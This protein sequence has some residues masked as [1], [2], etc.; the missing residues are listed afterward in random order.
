MN[1]SKAKDKCAKAK[2]K[3]KAKVAAKCGGKTKKAVAALAAL[4]LLAIGCQQVPSRS[5]TLTIRD[6][7]VNVYGGSDTNHVAS[8]EIGTQAMSIE[9]SGTE[10]QSPTQTT[11][12]KPDVDV[13]VGAAK[14]GGIL[15]TAAAAGIDRLKAPSANAVGSGSS[16]T[17]NSTGCEG[18]ACEYVPSND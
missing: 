10:T 18:G 13:S 17:V 9:N 8:V 6:C 12:T 15:E 16:A 2:D 3:A 1:I 4:T 14:G 5:Q 11:D 7:T